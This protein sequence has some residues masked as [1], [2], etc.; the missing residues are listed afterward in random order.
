MGSTFF[1]LNIGKS[2]LY[3]YQAALDTTAHNIT[4]AETDGYSKQV[5]GQQAGKALKVNSTYGMA[6]TGVDITGVTQLRDSYYDEKYWTSSTTLGEYDTKSH[7]MTEIENYFNEENNDGF[8]KTYSTLYD[9]LQELQKNPSSLTVRTQVT[10]YAES[11]GEYFNGISNSLQSIQEE[12][13]FEVKNQVDKVNSTAQQIASLTKQINTI[14]VNGMKAN[15]LR[16]QRNLLIDKLSKIANVSISEKVVGE[17]GVGVTSYVVKIDNQTLV[18]G[19]SSYKLKVVPRENKNNL[20]DIDGLYDIAWESGQNFNLSSSTLGGTLKALYEMRDGNNLSNLQGTASAEIGD[21]S[22]EM[23]DTNVNSAEK[24]NI[25]REGVITI[26]NQNYAYTGFEVKKDTVTNKFT[27]T[28]ELKDPVSS[29]AID[30]KASVGDSINYKGIPYYMNQMNELVR[31]YAENFNNI[32]RKGTTLNGKCGEDFFTATDQVSGR[33]Y[34]FG[35]LENSDDK[36]YYDYNT[37]TSDTG[38]YYEDVSDGQP[39]YGSYYYMTAANFKVNSNIISDPKN[40]ATGT[41]IT[42]GTENNDIVDKLLAMKTDKSIFTQGTAE[43]FFQSTVAEI[44]IDSKKA[45]SFTTNQE[46]IRNAIDNQRQSVSGVDKEE[47][48][49]NLMKFKNAYNLSAKIISVMN[50]VYDKL[51]NYMGA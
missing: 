27:Y 46:N 48:A 49:M 1:G 9:S 21:T 20:N 5:V 24:L 14:E 17:E 37:F 50:E 16:D 4:N 30:M 19:I 11:L 29:E 7:Y 33:Q 3:A 32:H 25:P 10:N 38:G 44:G 45:S 51:I 15:D 22:I 34:T 6:G 26:G 31:T 23:T 2:G 43:G 47:E 39:L 40:M 12:L 41:N 36:D 8:T 13:N 42:N 28:F 35:P 18:D